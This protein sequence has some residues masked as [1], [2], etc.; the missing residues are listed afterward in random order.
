MSSPVGVN[1]PGAV[2]HAHPG[3]ESC[4]DPIYH[5]VRRPHLHQL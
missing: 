4:P 1:R 2:H 5:S 3:L